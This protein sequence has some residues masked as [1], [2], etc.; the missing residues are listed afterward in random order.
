M[1]EN[2]SADYVLR[3]L[4]FGWLALLLF[5]MFGSVLESLHGFKVGW[6]LDVDNETRRLMW[7]L[8]HAHGTLLGLLNVAFAV[9]LPHLPNGLSGIRWISLAL[10]MA[11][12]LIPGGFFLGGAIVYSGDPGLG[13][14]LLPLGA[15][16]LIASIAGIAL[17]A[18]RTP[19]ES[20]STDES[21]TDSE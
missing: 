16:L 7:R 17:S 21:L 11:S 5:I 6:Y 20:G 13:I 15:F 3:H 1:I 18:W 14:L 8:C 4:R 10:R 19:N 9:S 2:R 12:L